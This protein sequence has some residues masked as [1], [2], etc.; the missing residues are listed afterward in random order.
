MLLLPPVWQS[1]QHSCR[2]FADDESK[3]RRDKGFTDKLLKFKS[4]LKAKV[5][6]LEEE[7][8]LSMLMSLQDAYS[9]YLAKA[10]AGQ[11]SYPGPGPSSHSLTHSPSP[12]HS[13]VY[14]P[15]PSPPPTTSTDL[16]PIFVQF[17][18]HSWNTYHNLP[19]QTCPQRLRTSI[20]NDPDRF[21]LF[22]ELAPSRRAV[23]QPGGASTPELTCTRG[24]I[25]STL[26]FRGI[27][28]GSLALRQAPP[29]L[30]TTYFKDLSAWNN[31]VAALKARWPSKEDTFFCDPRAY[32]QYLGKRKISNGKQ[33][34][35]AS[36]HAG[37]Q[38]VIDLAKYP[39][40]DVR[41]SFKTV[42][43]NVKKMK[44]ITLEHFGDLQKY[45][46]VADMVCIGLVDQPT[47]DDLG[48]QIK[49]L[50]AGGQKGLQM[51]GL[52]KNRKGGTQE[53][54]T[55]AVKSLYHYVD[56]TL[57]AKEKEEMDFSAVMLEHALCKLSRTDKIES[58]PQLLKDPKKK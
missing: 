43:N 20:Q 6:E 15:T 39:A 30:R 46:W 19:D 7:D 14:S 29:A 50:G 16:W 55:A 49:L 21:L 54:I 41:R 37:T 26:V 48:R 28:Y 12:P 56:Q 11:P 8:G 36:G 9:A 44:K 5:Q 57:T 38:W 25:F 2:W 17:L 23:T 4:L 31:H 52:V 45:L 13:P 10:T 58:Y 35:K 42:M 27:T 40:G 3:V 53:E 51:L 34:W 24:G 47:L 22:R 1:C 18:R 33:F 32:G